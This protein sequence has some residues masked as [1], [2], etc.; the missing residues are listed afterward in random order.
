MTGF[1]LKLH[2]RV[3]HVGDIGIAGTVVHIDENLIESHGITT[4]S[5]RW[6]DAE[7]DFIDIQWT[8]KLQ[9]VE[10][11]TDPVGTTSEGRLYVPSVGLMR[12]A[13]LQSKSADEGSD[14]QGTTK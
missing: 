8:D 6:D 4:C 13:L 7:D 12:E 14:T 1:W 10:V 11:P 5:V 3:E 9:L 2:D